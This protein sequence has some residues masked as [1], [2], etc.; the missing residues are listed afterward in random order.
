MN[1]NTVFAPYYVFIKKEE[2]LS[3]SDIL[4]LLGLN[5]YT[6]LG[7]KS[8]LND[9]D[10]DLKS[11]L[12]LTECD[13]WFHIMDSWFYNAWHTHQR[14]IYEKNIDYINSTGLLFET[15]SF[16][17]GDADDS[18]QYFYYKNHSLV[19]KYIYD[20]HINGS[21]LNEES[22]GKI[23]DGE[24]QPETNGKHYDFCMNLAASLGVNLNHNL[25][26][27]KCY[28]NEALE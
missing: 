3:D 25:N 28:A 15:F 7:L 10:L 2:K 16:M 21:T 24:K 9:D 11:A 19:R 20:E 12:F 17:V 22:F 1:S 27:V 18:I 26:K 5:D 14:A 13:N 6:Y 23:L 8:K 4:H